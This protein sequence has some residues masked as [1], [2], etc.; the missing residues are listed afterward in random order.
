VGSWLPTIPDSFAYVAKAPV[1]RVNLPEQAMTWE[2][3]GRNALQGVF[4]FGTA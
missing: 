1:H 2:F 4:H 3:S